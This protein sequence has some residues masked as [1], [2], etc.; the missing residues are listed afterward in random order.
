MLFV[1]IV[2]ILLFCMAV[3]LPVGF[4]LFFSSLVGIFLT[5]QSLFI[6]PHVV[7]SSLDNFVLLSIPL[8]ILMG[9][10]MLKG[11]I[12]E[13]IFDWANVWVR[14]LPGG[15]ILAAI[16]SCAV[17]AAISGSSV[18]TALTIGMVAIPAML[19]RGYQKEFV[20]GA[21]AAGG[22]LGILI[23]P[24]IPMI[25]YG[26]ITEESVGKLF[27]AGILPGI[28]ITILLMV[29]V[30]VTCTRN[31]HIYRK[32]SPSSWSER[33]QKT[34]NFLPILSLPIV[35]IGGIY[36]GIFTPTEASAFGVILSYLISMK[37][38]KIRDI[39]GIM[40][41]TAS[42]TVMLLTIVAAAK[43]FGHVMATM[44]VAQDLTK[45]IVESHVQ[46]WT[47]LIFVSVL[48]L[49]LGTLLDPAGIILILT[50][51]LFPVLQALKIDLIWFGVIFTVNM[52]IGNVTPPVGMNL[53]VLAGIQ[54]GIRYEEVVR[55]VLPFIIVLGVG[56]VIVMLFPTLSIWLPSFTK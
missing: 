15:L 19:S 22:T 49:F 12:G 23:P 2:F 25:L 39:F 26:T 42:T 36:I 51:I 54:K 11:G 31:P 40:K 56:L 8:F 10:I 21:L 9:Q 38:L 16:L 18:A 45:F 50:P 20:L 47:F 4:S 3:G 44:Q 14:H 1:F 41:E 46:P 28:V 17:F 34:I 53:F 35:V 43:L 30:A 37:K 24:S 29:Y 5:G 32:E 52:E 33:W 7:Y 13:K 48:L 27:I 55:G 6:I